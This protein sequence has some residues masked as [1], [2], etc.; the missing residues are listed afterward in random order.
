MFTVQCNGVFYQSLVDRSQLGKVQ[1]SAQMAAKLAAEGKWKD[2]TTQWLVTED[3]VEEV[4]SGVNFYNIQ[5][6]S[7]SQMSEANA[8]LTWLGNPL[9][10]D[11][12]LQY[13]GVKL[14][15]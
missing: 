7:G 3:V 12:V 1:E 11:T 5:Q 9:F 15:F 2:A 10:H 6:W 8:R 14:F 4:T 13:I